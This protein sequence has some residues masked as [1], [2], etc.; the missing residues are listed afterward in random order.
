MGIQSAHGQREGFSLK[1]GEFSPEERRSLFFAVMSILWVF[2]SLGAGWLLARTDGTERPVREFGDR[3]LE[4]WIAWLI[5]VAHPFFIWL[6]W[7]GLRALIRS[8]LRNHG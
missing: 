7:R 3:P 1:T 6:G 4:F 8:G 5:V 2:P